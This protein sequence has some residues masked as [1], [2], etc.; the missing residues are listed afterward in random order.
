MDKENASGENFNKY[1]PIRNGDKVNNYYDFFISKDESVIYKKNNQSSERLSQIFQ[2]I[3]K[4]ELFLGVLNG[5]EIPFSLRVHVVKGFDFEDDGSYKSSF[6]H[7]YRLDLLE[8]YEF[9]NEDLKEI[10][11]ETEV[12]LRNL[13]KANENGELIGDWALHNLV[14]SLSKK[15]I[16]NVDLEG[17]ITYNPIPTWANMDVISEWIKT[18]QNFCIN[19]RN[20][21]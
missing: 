2:D 20:M 9:S 10:I 13:N 3:E 18:V 8:F 17:F 16:V 12:L 15:K 6:V 1:F 5:T 11:A 21:I 19:P 14:Y 7:G 4:R